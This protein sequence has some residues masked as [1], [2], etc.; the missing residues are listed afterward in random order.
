MNKKAAAKLLNVSEKT[1]ERYKSAGKLS[2][3]LTRIVGTDGKSR[4]VLDFKETELQQL[5]Q[6]LSGEIVFPIIT[7]R[8]G[9]TK[10]QTDTD[11]QTQIDKVNTE[12]RESLILGQTQTVSVINT[13]FE[14]LETV[15]DKQMQASER[16]QKLMLSIAEA[17]VI[18]GLPKSYIR[19]SIKDGKLKAIIIG[20]SYKIKRQGLDKFVNSL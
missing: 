18:S 5:K 19:Q 12:N 9:Q 7:D 10:T 4:Q 14:R 3:R 8:H 16:A 1:I 11:R 15:F 13:I 20:R 6:E 2:A 17:S